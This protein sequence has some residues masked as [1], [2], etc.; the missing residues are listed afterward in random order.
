[1]NEQSHQETKHIW[2]HLPIITKMTGRIGLILLNL[3][4][5]SRDTATKQ[6]PFY[7]VYGR[8]P[9]KGIDTGNMSISPQALD[10]YTRMKEIHSEAIAANKMA[11]EP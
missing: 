9:W 5:R 1:M 3:C 4:K 2:Q 10:L 7:L 8:H 11:K 6:T